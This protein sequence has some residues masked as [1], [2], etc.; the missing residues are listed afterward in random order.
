MFRLLISVVSLFCIFQPLQASISCDPQLR[1]VLTTIRQ[2]PEACELINTALKDGPIRIEVNKSLEA[3]FGAFWGLD[4]R[5]IFVNC[6]NRKDAGEIIGSVIFELH[7]AVAT[8][9][10]KR[11]DNLAA[12][13]KINKSSYVREV[14][15]VEYCNSLKASEIVTKGIK[16]GFYPREAYLPVYSSFEE[17]FDV[18]KKYGHSAW[19]A[20]NFDEIM[21][22]SGQYRPRH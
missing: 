22:E 20:K 6:G 18:Q 14:E 11:L 13:G 16:Q 12:S 21:W 3:D 17:H 8:R 9:E 1:P 10:L 7:N 2:L 4:N 5:T 19:I 15:Y